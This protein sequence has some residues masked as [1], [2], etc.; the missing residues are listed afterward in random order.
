[1]SQEL[2][3]QANKDENFLQNIITGDETWVYG[4]DVETKAQSSQW[5]SKGSPR[6]K[7]ARQVRSNVKV[8]LTVFFFYSDGVA[9]HEFL[10]Q[11][12]TETKEYYVEVMKRLHEVIRKKRPDAWRSNRWMLHADNVPV[13]TSLLIR[14]FLVKLETTVIPQPPYL[15]DLAPQIKDVVERKHFESIDSIKE[16]LQEDLCSIPN[17][18]FQKCFK[19]LKKRWE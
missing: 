2:L 13:H 17:E 18:A 3:N 5:V 6:L 15:P 1:V 16:N 7:R 8:M 4:Y 12:K 14:H 19:G 9:H 11:G 10:P